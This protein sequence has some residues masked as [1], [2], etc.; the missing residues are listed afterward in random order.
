MLNLP[1]SPAALLP[2]PL[3]EEVRKALA[4]HSCR[5]FLRF[6]PEET[7]F[8]LPTLCSP[9]GKRLALPL[10]S[11]HT[12]AGCLLVES[13]WYGRDAL[14]SL[15]CG[16]TLF[17]TAVRICRCHIAGPF[18]AE[19]LEEKRRE[20]PPGDISCAY[21]LHAGSFAVFPA[22]SADFDPE[23]AKKPG[24][25]PYCELHLDH[26]DLLSADVFRP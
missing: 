25:G 9:D 11:E 5:K 20:D 4:D 3:P 17:E 12:E 23:S 22:G 26:P 7:L 6:F 8:E 14:L 10:V 24:E 1:A 16:E 21:E 15:I 18:F 13:L 19:L 2:Q